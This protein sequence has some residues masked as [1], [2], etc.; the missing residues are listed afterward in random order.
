M[1][2]LMPMLENA[3][4][5]VMSPLERDTQRVEIIADNDGSKF[6]TGHFDTTG[7]WSDAGKAA[8]AYKK[9]TLENGD[10][11]FTAG[12]ALKANLS[13]KKEA[14]ATA[15]W[16]ASIPSDGKY[17]VYV[18]YVSLPNSTTAAEY[19][20]KAADG[21]HCFTINQKMGGGTWIYLGHFPFKKSNGVK[22]IVELSNAGKNKK[23]CSDCRCRKIWRRHGQCST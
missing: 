6:A 17:A 11:P 16:K 1:P 12:T 23:I 7:N 22:T 10:H 14:S 21:D 8:F 13:G 5:Y 9:A 15:Q 3:G 18:S 20:V 19:I 2:F 4:A